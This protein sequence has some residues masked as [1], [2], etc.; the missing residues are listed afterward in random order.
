MMQSGTPLSSIRVN[1]VSGPFGHLTPGSSFAA[2]REMVC[3]PKVTG[4]L[5]RTPP[6]VVAVPFR[7]RSDNAITAIAPFYM[8]TSRGLNAPA[9]T[10]RHHGI[11]RRGWVAPGL[12]LLDEVRAAPRLSSEV[13]EV[14]RRFTAVTYSGAML[15]KVLADEHGLPASKSAV[16]V[17]L[18]NMEKHFRHFCGGPAVTAHGTRSSFVLPFQA[19]Q[20]VFI[21]VFADNTAWL[22]QKLPLAAR[23]EQEGHS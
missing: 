23:D 22:H 1:R 17:T 19:D 20:R 6:A 10:P 4:A 3:S 11:P 2:A 12:R 7:R 21:R 8:S 15:A 5:P 13:L 16:D 14:T 9:V 18:S